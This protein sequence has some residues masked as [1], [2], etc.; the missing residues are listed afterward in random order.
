MRDAGGPSA[1]CW[2]SRPSAGR[3]CIWLFAMLLLYVSEKGME[4]AGP[5]LPPLNSLMGASLLP[6][7]PFI[8]FLDGC[9]AAPF[10]QVS[11]GEWQQQGSTLS[12]HFETPGFER[13]DVSLPPGRVY[14]NVPVWGS[15][16]SKD[17]GEGWGGRNK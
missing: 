5:H 3:A 17:K 16:L 15:L 14:V 13:G 9:G 1:R 12:F 6:I 10:T 11:G 4:A 2:A 7:L 8:L